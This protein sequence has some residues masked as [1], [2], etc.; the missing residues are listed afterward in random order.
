M[1]FVVKLGDLE[2]SVGILREPFPPHPTES[3]KDRSIPEFAL[4]RTRGIRE[5]TGAPLRALLK[6][7]KSTKYPAKESFCMTGS[8]LVF[9]SVPVTDI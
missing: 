7:W 1:G 9:N 2:M 5:Q 3:Q 8:K 6:I 4:K